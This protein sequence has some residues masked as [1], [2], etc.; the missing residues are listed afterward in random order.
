MTD[1][2]IC[3]KCGQTKL[4]KEF[5]KH[6]R[7]K[8]D[9]SS[10]CKD[11]QK[12]Y[13]RSRKGKAAQ[14][15]H[16]ATEKRKEY[17]REH[18]RIR[19]LNMSEIKK[20]RW[21]QYQKQY[22]EN[23]RELSKEYQKQYKKTDCGKEANE[24]YRQS[25]KGKQQKKKSQ[26]I[27]DTQ[28]TQAGGTYTTAEWHN[29]CKFYDFHCLMCN[30]Q[31]PFEKLTVDH[32]KPVSKGGTSFIFNVQPLCQSCNSRKGTKEIDYRQ[33]LPDWIKRDRDTYLQLSLF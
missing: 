4:V 31:F 27:R 5:Y 24:K 13:N 21:A 32:I 2:K 29:L 25:A 17:H 19:R 14:K 26:A 33:T 12:I 22:R 6:I 3:T 11:C 1:R 7:A 20:K 30:H 8:D 15:R 9:Y 23:N 10:N 28:K 16:R 18:E